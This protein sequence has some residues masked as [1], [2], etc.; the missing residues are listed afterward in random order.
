MSER[1]ALQ[2]I[3]T[4]LSQW[5]KAPHPDFAKN[6]RSAMI[7]RR[8]PAYQWAMAKF[9]YAVSFWAGTAGLCLAGC[10]GVVAPTTG[11]GNGEGG[12]GGSAGGYQPP[13]AIAMSC[14]TVDPGFVGLRRLSRAELDRSLRDLLAQNGSPAAALPNEDS[15]LANQVSI[16]G[17]GLEKWEA[18]ADRAVEDAWVREAAGTQPANARL[19][20]C[21]LTASDPK[22]TSSVVAA[23]ARK[24]WRRPADSG[25]L[26]GFDAQVKA[27]LAAGDDI[28]TAVKT[29]FKSVLLSPSFLFRIEG[30]A[31]EGN[32]GELSSHDLAARLSFWLWGT[33]PDERLS[34]LADD[35]K[36]KE[37]SV[38]NAEIGRMLADPR[39]DGFIENFAT[40]WLG[41]S[42]LSVSRPDPAKF[43]TFNES[44]R[45]A[46]G[47]ETVEVFRKFLQDNRPV[48]ELI[49]ADFTVVNRELAGHYQ[50]PFNGA[51]G[52][53]QTIQVPAGPR[54]GLLGHAGL[55]TMTSAGARSSPVKRGKW[56]LTNLLCSKPPSPPADAVG[57][58]DAIVASTERERLAKH[59]EKP[60]CAACHAIIDP[61]GLGL[62]N[63]DPLGRY[64]TSY[65]N[66]IAIDPS[67]TLADGPSF[68]TY[69]E[70]REL[71]KKDE[72]VPGCLAIN[73]FRFAIGREPTEA[74]A[75]VMD[76]IRSTLRASGGIRDFVFALAATDAFSKQRQELKGGN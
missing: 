66:G 74:D 15:V 73:L 60:S 33:L 67:G 2:S 24:A 8:A 1:G 26:A 69:E 63:F 10:S 5:P 19:L 25:E 59:R 51:D 21:K 49:D 42:A 12:A 52:D 55:L 32:A 47:K 13:P 9:S 46:M 62:E 72:R 48:T 41:L 18:V 37:T 30:A 27:A 57:D 36:L 20:G 58:L 28:D 64:R 17:L 39:A 76:A 7:E 34:K 68:K 38:R 3:A 22:C 6:V 56:I 16:S 45:S 40:Y 61:I 44:L 14:G 23:F 11:Q 75:C 70:L 54:R 53:W 50:L 71:L 4:L 29:V 65:D 43:P 35:N 31:S